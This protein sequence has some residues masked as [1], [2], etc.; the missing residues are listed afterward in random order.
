MKVDAS[1]ILLNGI[2]YIPKDSVSQEANNVDGLQCVLV[3]TYAA[4]V[5]YGYLSKKESTP[6]G[7]EVTLINSR[8]VWSWS[9]AASLSQLAM[10]GTSK[11]D[12]C[13]MPCTV[14]QNEFVSIEIMPMTEKAVKSLN[15]VKIWSE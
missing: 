14:S 9:G 11:P 4:G 8:R 3:R 1:E 6:A 7:I 13:K 2:P 12:K 15:D 5:H 10:E